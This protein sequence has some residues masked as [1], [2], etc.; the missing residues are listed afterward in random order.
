[1]EMTA[2][3]TRTL[4]RIKE[5]LGGLDL[6]LP[7]SVVVRVGPCGKQS[8]GC[9]SDAAR[10]H[11]PFRSWTRSVS[12]KTVTRLLSEEQLD[13]YQALFDN[14]KKLKR[15]VKELEALSLEVVDHDPR[16]SR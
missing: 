14:H 16:W 3:Q 10:H 15:L 5:E 1:M 9:H 13:D 4:A 8:C 2:D 12:A 11:G 6:C 7:G